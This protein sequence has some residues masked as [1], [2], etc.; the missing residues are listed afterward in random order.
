[1]NA[2]LTHG[3]EGSKEVTDWSTNQLTDQ[4]TDRLGHREVIILTIKGGIKKMHKEK[5]WDLNIIEKYLKIL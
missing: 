4:P 5:I 1:M 2:Y 3:S